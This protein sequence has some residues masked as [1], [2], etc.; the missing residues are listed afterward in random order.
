MTSR[1]STECFVYVTLP[2]A[3]AATTAGRFVLEQTPTGDPIGRFVY[4]R[5]YLANPD[6]VEIDP[7]ELKLS[8]E[9]Y[10]TVRLNG[11][12]GA[13][14]DAGPDY[15][16]RRVI[17][18]HAGITQLGELDYLL[19]SPDDRA[20]ALSFGEKITPPAP[21]RRFNQT[22]DL[23]RLQE[24]A[25]AIVRDDIP[26]D[27]NAPQVQDLLLLGT[28]MGGARPKAV[29]QDQGALWIAKFARPDDRWN[30]ERVEDAMLRLARQCGISA[31]ESRIERVGGKDV[32][33]V[34]RFDRAR[35]GTAY[36]RSRMI[37]SLTVLRADDAVTARDRW[38]YILLV[39]EM[40]RVVSDP[41]GDARE[42]FRRIVF[43]ALISNIDDHPR[44]HALIAPKRS[45]M[46]SPAYDL[47]PAPQVSQDRRDLAMKCGDDGR[48]ANANNILS[49][50]ARFLLDREEAEKII[51]DMKVQVTKTWEDTVLASGASQR[52]VDAIRSAFI[53]PGFS[54]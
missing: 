9:T 13:I 44:N 51:A 12:F 41:K 17:E 15:W 53:Y 7:V 22:L 45:W 54:R 30:S 21:R 32:L 29:I 4:G 27:P 2:G 49:Q 36:T 34:K 42:L 24:T 48:F 1:H 14:R 19:E 50:H 11:V 5:S 35:A 43:N 47:T 25:E 10:E 20:G 26:N 16:G 3:R 46:L 33:L 23:A 40:R 18:K 39:E 37:S 38:S 52:D 8:N 31:A 28:S 6:A